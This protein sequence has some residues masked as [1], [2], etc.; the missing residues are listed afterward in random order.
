MT[1][2]LLRKPIMKGIIYGKFG[3]SL[4]V[5]GAFAMWMIGL[6]LVPRSSEYQIQMVVGGFAGA[7]GFF[8]AAC[9]LPDRR[10]VTF[11]S[12]KSALG[13]MGFFLWAGS[14]SWFPI[15]F[16]EQIAP[17]A[18]WRSLLGVIAP[19]LIGWAAYRL[20]HYLI[21][22]FRAAPEVVPA[23]VSHSD[24]DAAPARIPSVKR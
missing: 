6:Q 12:R 10:P 23:E 13:A 16:K 14:S 4:L 8:G 7:L 15:I 9:F 18:P 3:G 20:C 17:G 11:L 1:G 22:G 2:R 21:L 24:T 5:T 19:L